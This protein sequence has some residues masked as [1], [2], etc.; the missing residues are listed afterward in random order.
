MARFVCQAVWRGDRLTFLWSQGTAAFEPYALSGAEREQ[1]DRLAGNAHQRLAEALSSEEAGGDDRLA[2]LGHQLYRAIFRLGAAERGSAAEVQQWLSAAGQGEALEI[3]SDVPGRVP[4]GLVCEQP[5]V[6][7]LWGR[8]FVLGTGRRV[9][10]LRATPLLENPTYV[11]ALDA[12]LAGPSLRPWQDITHEILQTYDGL[13]GR[14]R[15]EAPDVIVVIGHVAAEGLRLGPDRLRLHELR[16]WIDE[17]S[18]G[19]PDPVIIVLGVGA[20]NALGNWREQIADAT[21]LLPGLIAN[22]VPLP[23]S[24]AASLAMPFLQRF[25]LDRQSV[26]K[27]LLNVRQE[28]GL[29]AL[30]LTA[31]CPL[32]VQIADDT[33]GELPPE[34]AAVEPMPLPET[35]YRPLSAYDYKDRP[36]F[37]GRED[38]TARC[39]SLLDDAQTRGLFLHGGPGAGKTSLLQAGVMPYLEQVGVGYRLLRDRA[40]VETPTAEEDYPILLLRST[41]DLAGQFA[42]AL[43]DFCSQP[44]SY[45]TPTG[46][47]VTVDLPA[48][49]R[50]ATRA[51]SSTAIQENLRAESATA[52]EDPSAL[53]GALWNALGENP[54]LLGEV[55]DALTRELPFELVIAI[56]QGEE[57]ITEV[58]NPTEAARRAEALAMLMHLADAPARCKVVLAMRSEYLARLTSLLPAGPGRMA[59]REF[60]LDELSREHLIE[61]LEGPTFDATPPCTD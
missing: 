16:A 55:L 36:L 37:L 53:K 41:G 2:E 49:L 18:E 20:V 35:P 61:A 17:A 33:D 47:R 50:Q 60:Y 10:P 26:G 28:R 52:T 54:R 15:R 21:R 11:L 57:L 45:T 8:R 43:G 42:D 39:A 1:F 56:D 3:L 34:A 19:N 32:S 27:A 44:Y 40:P 29:P 25:V 23:A 38:E 4:W 58:H 51:T 30:A 59:W 24:Q 12:E 14:V 7:A 31:Y 13:A 22:E 9:N 6:E 48:Q 5:R 46:R